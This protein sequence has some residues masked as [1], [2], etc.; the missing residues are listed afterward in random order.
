[1]DWRNRAIQSLEVLGGP[2]NSYAQRF[3]ALI[4]EEGRSDLDPRLWGH[5]DNTF[6]ESFCLAAKLIGEAVEEFGVHDFS[7]Q[8]RS[9][10]ERIITPSA[11]IIREQNQSAGPIEEMQD[12]RNVFVVHGRNEKIRKDFFNFLRAL[13][14]HPIEWAEALRTTGKATP[15]V[16]EVLDAAFERAQAVIVLLTPDDE[17]RLG[18]EL[19]SAEEGED[20]RQYHR[21]ARPNVLFEAGMAFGRNPDHTLLVT[22]GPV[23]QFSDI[24]GRHIVRL[25]NDTARRQD[26]ADRLKTA[27][28]SVKIDGRDWLKTGNFEIK[29]TQ[30]AKAEP[31][32]SSKLTQE[33][34]EMLD[35]LWMHESGDK[36]IVQRIEG[37]KVGVITLLIEKDFLHKDLF[38]FAGNWVMPKRITGRSLF[39]KR[40]LAS[41]ENP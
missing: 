29:P 11:S 12:L 13:G 17:V 19:W 28:C 10:V 36:Q 14:L 2:N 30:I 22:V 35:E 37:P 39:T 32:N 20:E 33:E 34:K 3:K 40:Y 26:I 16:G 41:R 6:E 38:T 25:S 4:F 8:T 27:G 15:F 23:K 24:G 21:Q 18:K 9:P 5:Q 31:E 7:N 1:M